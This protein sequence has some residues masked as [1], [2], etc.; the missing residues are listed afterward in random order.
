MSQ[1]AAKRLPSDAPAPGRPSPS[2][3]PTPRRPSSSTTRKPR[4][5]CRTTTTPVRN[6]KPTGRGRSPQFPRVSVNIT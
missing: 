1:S 6:I 2:R 3:S 4:V 5:V